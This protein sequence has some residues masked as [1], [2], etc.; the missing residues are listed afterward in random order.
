MDDTELVALVTLVF[1]LVLQSAQVKA[2]CRGNQAYSRSPTTDLP[3]MITQGIQSSDDRASPVHSNASPAKPESFAGDATHLPVTALAGGGAGQERGR[4]KLTLLPLIFLIFFQVAGGPYG[5]EPAVQAAGPLFALLGFLVFPFVWAVPESLVTTELSTAMPDNGG[6]V[7]WVG[8]AFGPFAGS[9]MG[10]WKYVCAA[11]GAA[12]FPA[13]CSDY[14][15]RAAPAVSGGGARAATI[16]TFNVAL[17]LLSCTGLSVCAVA[18]GLAALSPFV[19]MVGVALPKIRPRRWGTTAPAKDWKLLLNTLFWN[20]NGWDSV[21]T[22]AGEVERPGRTFPAALVS[23]VCIGSLGYLLPLM[24]ATGAVDAPPEAWGDGY[25]ADAAGVIAG[26]WLKYWIEV[27][28]AVSSVGLYSAT[29]S[30][31]SYLLAGMAEL[32]HL[33]SPLAARAP[34]FGTPWA[35][36][37][38]TGTVALGMSFLSFD[39]IV[40]VTNFLYGLGMLLELAA[41]LWLRARRPGLPRPYRAPAGAAGAAAV[42]AVPAAFLVLVVAVAGWKV[43]A[44]GAGFTAA[45]VAVYYLMRFCRARGCVEFARPEGEGGE[46]GGCESGKEGQHCDA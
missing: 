20:L 22:M 2:I 8:R 14:L 25:F 32:G 28:A 36:I 11:I 15:V 40:F 46:R 1:H 29:L 7:L 41:F 17:T 24:A 16:V 38:A 4:N 23:A 42:C 26:E 44:A 3:K 19:V 34:R 43:C 12:A 27:G 37:A 6:Y 18:L 35:S 13:L 31:A 5:A 21:S 33:P 45:G 9:L 30:S 10:T 39:S